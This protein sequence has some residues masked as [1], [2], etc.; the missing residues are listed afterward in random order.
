LVI[1]DSPAGISAAVS[2]AMMAIGLCGGSHC[3]PEH[4]AALHAC[5][6]VMVIDDM[7]Q[8]PVAIAKLDHQ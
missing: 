8:L 1:E 5:G 4:G 3:S 7:R 2:A 6:A